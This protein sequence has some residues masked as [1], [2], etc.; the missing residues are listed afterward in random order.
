MAIGYAWVVYTN[1]V[2]MQNDL[3]RFLTSSHLRQFNFGPLSYRWNS[4]IYRNVLWKRVAV[5]NIC[6]LWGTF[7]LAGGLAFLKGRARTLIALS[8]IAFFLPFLLFENLHSVHDYYQSANAIFLIFAV[9]LAI[10]RIAQQHPRFAPAAV[11][12]LMIIMAS[13]IWFFKYGYGALESQRYGPEYPSFAIAKVI[14]LNTK[15]DQPIIVFGYDWSSEIP[16]FSN[17]RG[18]AVPAHLDA[19]SAKDILKNARSHLAGS[20]PGA[21]VFCPTPNIPSIDLDKYFSLAES[22]RIGACEV[23]IVRG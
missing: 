13:N 1:H 12:G 15:P 8:L 14:D 17:R 18:L 6:G 7:C 3:G 2:K 10:S 4:E 19:D 21:V 11:T 5:Q 20:L 16:F 9:A 23:W 22:K